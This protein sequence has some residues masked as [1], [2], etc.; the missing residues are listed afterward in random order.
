MSEPTPTA[1]ERRVLLRQLTEKLRRPAERVDR[2]ALTGSLESLLSVRG[3][4][5]LLVEWLTDGDG[6]GAVS[7]AA[8]TVHHAA[9]KPGISEEAGLLVR[10]WVVVDAAGEFY[11]PGASP[12]EIDLSRLVLIR[13]RNSTDAA[14]ALEQALRCRGVGLTWAWVD[15]VSERMLRRWKLAVEAGGGVGVL[16]RSA[17]MR[18]EPSWADVRWLVTPLQAPRSTARRWRVELLYCRG[19]LGG[20]QVDVELDHATNT[21]CVV[22][23]VGGAAPW[24]A[25]TGA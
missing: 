21:V 1:T 9:E 16:F 13:P 2:W 25:A 14:W 23:A 18:R 8:A 20:Q 4:K 10:A 19:Q 11:A 6:A 3:Q 22:P 15:H 5:G 7:L 24:R 12:A 17:R